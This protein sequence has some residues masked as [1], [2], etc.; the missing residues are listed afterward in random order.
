M[1]SFAAIFTWW[2]YPTVMEWAMA[3]TITKGKHK[4]LFRVQTPGSIK[5]AKRLRRFNKWRWSLVQI[6]DFR[7]KLFKVLVALRHY[8]E[9]CPYKCKNIYGDTMNDIHLNHRCD[10]MVEMFDKYFL[11]KSA[12]M[13]QLTVTGHATKMFSPISARKKWNLRDL[14]KHGPHS[15]GG[16]GG[17][18]L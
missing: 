16:L 4:S 10:D 17:S 13:H 12:R 15:I 5:F 11:H 2:I 1:P 8:S 18:G 7:Q 3:S 6:P 14:T 9:E